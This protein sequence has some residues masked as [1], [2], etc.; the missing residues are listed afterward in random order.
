MYARDVL[1]FVYMCSV[2]AVTANSN[3][4]EPGAIWKNTGAGVK[5]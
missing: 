4:D 3:L 5:E 1:C 2:L